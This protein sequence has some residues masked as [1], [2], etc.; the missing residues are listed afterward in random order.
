MRSKQFS[1][2]LS[3]SVTGICV[4]R[5]AKKLK[6]KPF[7]KIFKHDGIARPFLEFFL[8]ALTI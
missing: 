1:D 3:L 2:N 8:K 5:T 4:S 6:K 7:A